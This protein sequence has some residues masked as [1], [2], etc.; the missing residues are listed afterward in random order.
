VGKFPLN[1][2]LCRSTAQHGTPK[3]TLG[4]IRS[5]PAAARR[6]RRPA[7]KTVP[8]PGL[9]GGGLSPVRE[10]SGPDGFSAR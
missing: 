8:A 10:P 7:A 9:M 4:F 3:D 2:Y 1:P 6:F 5:A